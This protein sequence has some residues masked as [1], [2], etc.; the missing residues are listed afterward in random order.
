MRAMHILQ[1]TSRTHVVTPTLEAG[2]ER[3]LESPGPTT[4]SRAQIE[5]DL[6][7]LHAALGVQASWINRRKAR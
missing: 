4:P 6:D 2:L 7:A 5:E 1:G 3:L